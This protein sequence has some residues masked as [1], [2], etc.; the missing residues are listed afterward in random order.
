MYIKY[1]F[2]LLANIS[3][4]LNAG[5]SKSDNKNSRE[6]PLKAACGGEENFLKNLT[7]FN[8]FNRAL[9]VFCDKYVNFGRCF[10]L[11]RHLTAD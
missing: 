7:I 2:G 4:N 6:K 3:A 10:F 11:K 8:E 1:R 5:M 9:N